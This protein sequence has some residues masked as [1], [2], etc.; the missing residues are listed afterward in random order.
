MNALNEYMTNEM[1]ISPSEQKFLIYKLKRILYDLSKLVLLSLFFYSLGYFREF[2]FAALIAAPLRVYSGG[3]HFRHYMSCLLFSL[4]Y[5]SLV[6]YG[7]GAIPLPLHVCAV[8]ML[9]CS[10]MNFCLSPVQSPSRPA[11]PA[12]EVQGLKQKTFIL[13]IYCAL[14]ILLFYHTPLAPVGYWTIL[15]HSAQLVIANMR[16]KGGEKH[17]K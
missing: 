2:L 8:L 3:L 10:I 16:R 12:A 6:I 15:L 1:K 7:L 14:M 5:F 4:G 17:E 9:L 11:L 13:T